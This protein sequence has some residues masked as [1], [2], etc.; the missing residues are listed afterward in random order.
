M[1][2]RIIPLKLVIL[3]L[4][5]CSQIDNAADIIILSNVVTMEETFPRA[6]ALVIKG[7]KII[8]VGDEKSALKYK[9]D[10]T[11]LIQESSGM[12]LPGFIDS[13]VHLIWGGIEMGECQLSGLTSKEEIISKIEIYVEEHADL[14]WIRGN[15]WSL[16]V[17][18]DGNPSK[19]ILDKINAEKP[20]YFLSADGHSAWVN[21]KALSIAG[22]NENTRDPINGRI[23]RDSKTRVPSGVLRE[24]AMA[25]VES[26]IPNYTKEQ[27]KNGLLVSVKEAN[28]FGIT[29]ILDAGTESINQKKSEENYFDGL[30]AYREATKNQ[31]ISLRVNS[32]QYASPLS[33]RKDLKHIKNRRFINSQGSMNTVK[34]FA[35]GVIEAGTGALLDPYVGTN[36]FGVLNWDPDTLKVVV[37]TI[38][39]EGFQIH[40]HAI[41]DKAIRTTLDAFE[42]ARE[43]NGLNNMRHMISHAQLIHPEDIERF[44]KLDIITSFQPLWAYPDPYMKELT[45][46]V[47]GPIRSKWNY[48]LKSLLSSGARITAGS[49]WSVTSL[50]PLF[51]IEVAVTRRE[52]GSPDGEI[53]NQDEIVDLEDILKAYTIEGAFSLFRENE[54]G[55]LKK[56]KLADV[57]LLD[58]NLFKIPPHEIHQAKVMMTIFNGRVV[59]SEKN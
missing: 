47:L 12:V 53:L 34:I 16:P 24:D 39:N 56:G 8:F 26:F 44:K 3:F 31:E 40:F 25:L 6:D 57:I 48:P 45:I 20:M 22:L 10:H 28:K 50:N 11:L 21:S 35:D 1:F 4:F 46:P 55:S 17:F 33:W 41:G 38:E 23:E 7:S 29:S 58:K 14:N 2:K 52:L 19:Y 30:D 32:S 37:S 51:G 36:N 42:Y 27:I 13:H 43:K 9:S 49:D 18:K 54:I 15:G 59:Y 5:C